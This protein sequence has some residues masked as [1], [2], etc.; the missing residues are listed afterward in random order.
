M[1]FPFFPHRIISLPNGSLG[2]LSSNGPR[3][4]DT[5]S[6]NAENQINSLTTQLASVSLA[7]GG[8]PDVVPCPLFKQPPMDHT[9]S[10]PMRPDK[11]LRISRAT[12]LVPFNSSTRKQPTPMF[13]TKNSSVQV[14]NSRLDTQWDH[15]L[16]EK[17]MNE[18]Y[19]TFM[20]RMNQQGHNSAGLKD[21]VDFYKTR[22]ELTR[23]ARLW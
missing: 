21:S 10:T 1:Q 20:S 5:T 17:Q 6:S 9:P 4:N 16:R 18:M 12:P 19:E 11:A 15:E 14:V 13:L 3:S 23:H 7:E 8:A 22:S 2:G